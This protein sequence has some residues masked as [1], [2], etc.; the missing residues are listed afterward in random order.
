MSKVVLYLQGRSKGGVIL[1]LNAELPVGRSEDDVLSD[2]RGCGL[3]SVK[4]V[5]KPSLLPGSSEVGRAWLRCWYSGRRVNF[6]DPSPLD[7]DIRDI[8]LGICREPRWNGQSNPDMEPIG[9]GLHSLMV[10]RIGQELYPNASAALQFWFLMHDAAEYIL[11]DVATPVKAVVG[12]NGFDELEEN[13]ERAVL[14]ML[15][16]EPFLVPS[17]KRGG[18][19]WLPDDWEAKRKVA[20]RMSAATEA[21]QLCGW[22][23]EE[24]RAKGGMDYQ[25]QLWDREIKTYHWRNTMERFLERYEELKAAME[26]DLA[27]QRVRAMQTG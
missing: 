4:V 26:K 17:E 16:F 5:A 2:L 24:I 20:D 1:N 27:N 19:R 22:P 25:G 12:K 8:A 11:K 13:I 9:V 21:Y 14:L 15:G 3:R 6:I 23:M 18:K 7:M 10:W